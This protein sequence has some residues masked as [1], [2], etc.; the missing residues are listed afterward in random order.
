M[1]EDLSETVWIPLL[2]VLLGIIALIVGA[3]ILMNARRAST[4]PSTPVDQNRLIDSLIAQIAELDEQHQRGE[5]NHDVYRNRRNQ[6]KQRLAAL[7]DQQ[8]PTP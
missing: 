3:F 2:G 7:M 4:T 8:K 1:A 5:L 6:L